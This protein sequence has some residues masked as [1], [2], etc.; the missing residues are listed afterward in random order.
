[1]ISN[2]I[3]IYIIFYPELISYFSI[4]YQLV[5]LDFDYSFQKN[6]KKLVTF[7]LT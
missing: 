6:S 5:L 4:I 2:I 1:M 7:N 3:E